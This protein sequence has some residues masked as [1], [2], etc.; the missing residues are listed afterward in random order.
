MS[1]ILLAGILLGLSG[2]LAP[3]PLLTLVA[4]ET[5][6]HGVR[7]GVRVALAPLL[8]D[9]PIILGTVLLLRPLTD[10]SLPLALIHLGGGLYLAWLGRQ[11]VHFRGAEL[12]PTDPAGSLRRGV[13]TNFLNPS[14]YLF[15]LAVGTPTVLEAWQ[16]GWPAAVGVR[17]C[18]LCAAG[19]IQGAAGGRAGPCP[20]GIAQPGLYCSDAWLGPAAAGVC[21]AVPAPKLAAADELRVAVALI[22][23]GNGPERSVIH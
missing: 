15:W 8:T 12:E 10:Q 4:S 17:R 1:A 20:P 14:P 23:G 7:A 19:G 9:L 11:G 5:L 2:G 21:P 3:G 16:H 22:S 18:V 13:I 6:R